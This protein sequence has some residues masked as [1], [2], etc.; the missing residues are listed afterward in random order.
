M[1]LHDRNL[2]A[3][4]PRDVPQRPFM[5]E[6]DIK[7]LIR[8]AGICRPARLAGSNNLAPSIMASLDFFQLQTLVDKALTL[9]E[10]WDSRFRAGRG[11][12]APR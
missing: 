7:R 1:T 6:D 10:T 3:A 5:L 8:V 9:L 11:T 2:L 4:P 12:V